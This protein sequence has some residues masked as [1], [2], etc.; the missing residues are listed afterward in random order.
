MSLGTEIRTWQGSD[1]WERRQQV[2]ITFM[3]KLKSG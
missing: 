2:E 1:I 3:N